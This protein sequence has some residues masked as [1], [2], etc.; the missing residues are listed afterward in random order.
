VATV[1]GVQYYNDSKATTPLSTLR[2]LQAFDTPVI[3]LAG[4]YDKGTPFDELGQVIQRRAKVALL[5]GTTASKL[6]LA[7]DQAAVHIP[8]GPRP[9]VHQL[10]TLDVAMAQATRLAVPG[11][12]VLLSPAC[13]SYDQYPHYEARGDHF[14]Q[15]VQ[16][17][18]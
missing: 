9:Q 18:Q 8:G 3:L 17:L 10:D 4:G 6:A 12:V 14:R 11:D 5:Y 16:T 13:A 15:L 1:A 2:A 7:I